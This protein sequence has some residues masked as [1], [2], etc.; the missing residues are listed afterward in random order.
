V[1]GLT[2]PSGGGVS[3][4]LRD[5][6]EV[7]LLPQGLVRIHGFVCLPVEF[8]NGTLGTGLSRAEPKPVE[9]VG[10]G[11]PGAR[12]F[13][14]AVRGAENERAGLV[15]HGKQKVGENSRVG[16]LNLAGSDCG[17]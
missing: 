15:E 17:A 5:A 3:H 10:D 4:A 2:N 16:R 8:T 1:T 9:K 7:A 14:L 12:A 11:A 13:G 6:C